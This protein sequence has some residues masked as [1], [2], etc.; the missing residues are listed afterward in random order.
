M[1]KKNI[2]GLIQQFGMANQLAEVNLDTVEKKYNIDLGRASRE[3]QLE[4]SYFPQFDESVRKE[5]SDMSRHYEVFYCLEKT[6]R[7]LISDTISEAEGANWWESGRVPPKLKNDVDNRIQ[8]ETD[9][10][11]T[12]RS[13]E[14]I[15]FTTFGELGELIKSNWDI[16]GSIFSSP[17][18]VERVLANL[19]ILR[20]PIAHCSKLAEDE[21]IRLELSLRDWFRL[22]E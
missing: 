1:N 18:A 19:N 13:D 17:R 3:E 9:S 21:I 10:A 11:V 2:T 7:S 8:R 22:M 4:E 20:G 12:L 6:I 15:D 5:A 16:F 14:P